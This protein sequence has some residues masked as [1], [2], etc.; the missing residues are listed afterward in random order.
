MKRFGAKS[1][2]MPLRLEIQQRLYEG[3]DMAIAETYTT[4]ATT[5]TPLREYGAAPEY[6]TPAFA[7]LAAWVE[8]IR[9]LTKPDRVHWIDGSR[10]ENDALLRSLVDEGKITRL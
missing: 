3:A 2:S 10:A 4:Q 7:E 8:E 1:F 6:D 5:A 9:A